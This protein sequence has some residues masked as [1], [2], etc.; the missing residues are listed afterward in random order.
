ML[1]ELRT[2]QTFE[3]LDEALPKGR[4][5]VVSCWGVRYQNNPPLDPWHLVCKDQKGKVHC[6]VLPA[7]TAV[8][9]IAK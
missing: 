8:K 9:R 5:T 2:K 3:F 4:L 7:K 1:Y 6:L